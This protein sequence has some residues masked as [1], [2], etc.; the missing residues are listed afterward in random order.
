M[1]TRP[2][3]GDYP[4]YVQGY[5]ELVPED[6]IVPALEKQGKETLRLLQALSEEKAGSR[7]AP[8]KWSVKEVLRHFTDA[9]RVFS[10]RALAIARGDQQSLPGFDEKAYAAT[11]D[12][13]QRPIRDLIDEFEAARRSTVAMLRGLSD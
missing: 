8:G 4:A 9:E 12:A 5:I 11:S 13:D 2:A 6:D 3:A 1:K 10:Y 7:Y